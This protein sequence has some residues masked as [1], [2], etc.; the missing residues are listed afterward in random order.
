MILGTMTEREG[1]GGI[2]GKLVTGERKV[3]RR[4]HLCRRKLISVPRERLWVNGLLDGGG[5][6]K[7]TRQVVSPGDATTTEGG[8]NSRPPGS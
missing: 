3:E 2:F 5:N 4:V 7:L 1:E 6:R 8:A